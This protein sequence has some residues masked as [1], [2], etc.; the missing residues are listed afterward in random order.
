VLQDR[1][2]TAGK[3]YVNTSRDIAREVLEVGRNSV[4]FITYHLSTGNST[5]IPSECI[6][7]HFTHWVDHE[8]TLSEMASIQHQMM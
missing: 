5:G 3:V 8:A 4:T 1:K 2:V 7:Q 6:K